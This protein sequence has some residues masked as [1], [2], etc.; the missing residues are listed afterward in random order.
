M[1]LKAEWDE[2][3]RHL[4]TK[5]EVIARWQGYRLACQGRRWAI[6]PG[7]PETFT[8][9]GGRRRRARAAAVATGLSLEELATWLGLPRYRGAEG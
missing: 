6:Y 7:E 2:T 9:P 3:D 8:L 5:C 4:L 1:S